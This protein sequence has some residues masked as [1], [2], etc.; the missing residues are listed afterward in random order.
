LLAIPGINVVSAAELA[1]EMGP[2]ARYAN[3]NAITGR[4]GLF[5]S[6]HQSDQKDYVNGPLIRLALACVAGD[7]PMRHPAFK[8]PDSILEKLRHFHCEHGTPMDR[9]LLDL[10]ATVDQLPYKTRGHEAAVVAEVLE[11]QTKRRRGPTPIG[12]ILPAVL[13]RLGNRT[14]NTTASGDRP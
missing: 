1:A 2:P 3:A 5:P 9:L 7:E 10:E 4:A 12:E 13:A 8:Q 14:N 6:R 11:Q